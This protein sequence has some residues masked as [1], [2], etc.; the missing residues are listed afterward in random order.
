MLIVR[1]EQMEALGAH[2]REK[3]IAVMRRHLEGAFPQRCQGLGPERVRALIEQGMAKADGF[4]LVAEQ[5]VGGLIHFMFESHPE[6]D[7]RPDFAWAVEALRRTDVG[8]TERVDELFAEWAA[9]RKSPGS[10]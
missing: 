6:F 1:Q 5:D 4:G 2:S 10:A 7:Q 8:P 3:F 9:R